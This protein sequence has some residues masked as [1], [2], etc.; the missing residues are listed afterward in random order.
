MEVCVLYNVHFNV[1]IIIYDYIHIA[2][3]IFTF[4]IESIKSWKVGR[5]ISLEREICNAFLSNII[6]IITV[7]YIFL[8]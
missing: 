7:I 5:Y 6:N 8:T 2:Y 1:H 3:R 4:K